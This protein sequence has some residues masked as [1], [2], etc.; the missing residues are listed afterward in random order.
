MPARR[1]GAWTFNE[2]CNAVLVTPSGVEL[3]LTLDQEV[4]EQLGYNV[5]VPLA[6]DILSFDGDSAGTATVFAGSLFGA[7]VDLGAPVEG[8]ELTIAPNT[9]FTLWVTRD[10]EHVLLVTG[11][12]ALRAVDVRAIAS[13]LD[14]PI[15]SRNPR[16]SS[17]PAVAQLRAFLES[18]GLLSNDGM[19]VSISPYARSIYDRPDVVLANVADGFAEVYGL[20]TWEEILEWAGFETETLIDPEVVITPDNP[21]QVVDLF[22]GLGI[23]EPTSTRYRIEG[24]PD[25]RDFLTAL[26][27][28]GTPN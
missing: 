2:P 17:V 9:E 10:Y 3:G 16:E 20:Q 25:G 1:V 28:F 19:Q 12:G 11:T 23:F 22:I 18:I 13:H 14:L 24:T 7:D 5:H 4:A 21:E 27:E 26:L 8:A 15:P 6:H